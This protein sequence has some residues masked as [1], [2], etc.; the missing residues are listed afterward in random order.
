MLQKRYKPADMYDNFVK[1]WELQS[2]PIIDSV[3]NTEE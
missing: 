3:N 1:N 2:R